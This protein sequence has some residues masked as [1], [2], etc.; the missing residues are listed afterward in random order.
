MRIHRS[1]C[2]F[3]LCFLG[4]SVSVSLPPPADAIALR[5]SAFLVPHTVTVFFSFS[6]LSRRTARLA[7]TKW[8]N[9]WLSRTAAVT[10]YIS[11]S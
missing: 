7:R 1:A 4:C 3:C 8:Y 10:L 5:P 9:S 11:F 6:R 2:V